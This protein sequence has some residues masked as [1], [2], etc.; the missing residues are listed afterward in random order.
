MLLV[1]ASVLKTAGGLWQINFDQVG[2]KRLVDLTS[3]LTIPVTVL[4]Q[5]N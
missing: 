2:T 3:T 4:L 1:K 5:G